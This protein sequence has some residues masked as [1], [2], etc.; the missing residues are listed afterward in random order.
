[1]GFLKNPW[2]SE[3]AWLV[4]LLEQHPWSWNG[5]QREWGN[6]RWRELRFCGIFK[7]FFLSKGCVL[8][9][10]WTPLGF[11]GKMGILWIHSFIRRFYWD[12]EVGRCWDTT[13]KSIPVSQIPKVSR[14]SLKLGHFRLFTLE[15]NC[16]IPCMEIPGKPPSEWP[17]IP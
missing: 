7:V 15:L 11:N 17:K 5:L 4:F 10:T 1:M 9:E 14:E 6:G 3:L 13:R 12:G 16:F 2:N 8:P